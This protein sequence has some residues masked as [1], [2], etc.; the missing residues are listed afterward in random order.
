MNIQRNKIAIVGGGSVGISFLLQLVE[1]AINAKIN[2]QIEVLLFEPQNIIGPGYAYQADFTCNLLN[3]RAD[4]MS[5]KS[6]E[7]VHF[8]SWLKANESLWKFD[9]PDV[10]ISPEAFLPRSLFGLYL[11][12]MYELAIKQAKQHNILFYHIK[13]EVIDVIPINNH[14]NLLDTKFHGVF[15]IDH[16][17]ICMGNMPS[18]PIN[19]LS[20]ISGYFNSP[21]PC[22]E[23]VEQIPTNASVCIVGTSLSAIDAVLSLKEHGHNGNIICVSRN[24]RLPSVRGNLNQPLKLKQLTRG[25]IDEIAQKNG[26]YITLWNIAQV[27]LNE[28]TELTGEK[29]DIDLILNAKIGMHD[30]IAQEISQSNSMER[31]WQSIIYATNSIIDYVWHKLSDTDKY[32]FNKYFRSQWLSYRVSFPLANAQKIRNLLSTDQLHVFGGINHISYDNAENVFL[33]HILN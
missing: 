24:G 20:G 25:T 3:T 21:Y 19:N 13:D 27:L 7:K 29:C 18:K 33:T 11:A 17:V 8:I 12:N 5:I 31:I 22:K 16:L 1:N 10:E 23:V 32:I 6:N 15:I 14:N 30:Y 28:Y 26:G 2:D 4:S 9:Y